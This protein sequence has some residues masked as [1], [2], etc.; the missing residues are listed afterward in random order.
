VEAAEVA[1]QI[2]EYEKQKADLVY[3]SIAN[4]NT[5]KASSAKQKVINSFEKSIRNLRNQID[6]KAAAGPDVFDMAKKQ[7]TPP[8]KGAK[9]AR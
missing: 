5:K 7:V 1:A 4:I 2:R 9:N 3:M 6:A 8:K